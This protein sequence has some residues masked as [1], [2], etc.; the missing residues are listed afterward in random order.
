VAVVALTGAAAIIALGLNQVVSHAA[1]E[2]RPYWTHPSV[3]VLASKAND[4]AFPSDHATVA[5]ALAL[6][7]L[8]YSWRFGVPA[9]VMALFLAFSRVYVGAHYPGDVVAGLLLGAVIA[10]LCIV[11]FRKPVTAIATWSMSTPFALLVTNRWQRRAL[12]DD[13]ALGRREA[14]DEAP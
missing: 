8:W 10:T 14:A 13:R 3:L 9:L 4:Y 12:E 6:G 2:I 7:L 1:G 5:G 11:A